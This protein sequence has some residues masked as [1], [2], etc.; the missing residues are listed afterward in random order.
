MI[1][2]K[3]KYFV[4]LS[5]ITSF[6]LIIL[7]SIVFYLSKN[8]I[9]WKS[10]AKVND[11]N[12]YSSKRIRRPSLPVPTKTPVTATPAPAVEL[13]DDTLF[14]K[15]IAVGYGNTYPDNL[16]AYCIQ[17]WKRILP[18]YDSVKW[19]FTEISERFYFCDNSDNN[20]IYSSN[21][22]QYV[23]PNAGLKKFT[24]NRRGTFRME[25][26]TGWE[27]RGGCNL[28]K[29]WLD[30]TPDPPKYGN[31]LTNWPHFLVGQIL[32][33]SYRPSQWDPGSF[34]VI[35]FN[36][37][38]YPTKYKQLTFKARVNLLDL[39]RKGDLNW[40]CPAG[41]WKP[42]SCNESVC[43]DSCDFIPNHAIFY[44]AFVFWRENRSESLPNVIYQLLPIIYSEDGKNHVLTKDS[45]VMGDQFGET[46]YFAGTG[47][48]SDPYVP[49]L[50][51]G[52]KVDIDVDIIKL[53]NKAFQ[54]ISR[55]RGYNDLN[56]K[57]Y[58]IAVFLA[59]WEIWGAYRT[60]IEVSD[61]SFK[62]SKI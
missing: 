6:L 10:K 23:S 40:N 15:G 16:D 28:C 32:S 62:G 47:N 34:G 49:S 22:I 55:F 8:S 13:L 2:K 35:P 45:F 44:F 29:K 61:I 53:T 38:I 60:D 46:V 18:E 30:V 58:Y 26:D 25:Y 37:R 14:Q 24:T 52:K 5:F 33:P 39:E 54:D 17:R 51:K 11:S 7:F 50:Q 1:R 21:L 3:N 41:D 20:P 31:P 36:E 59:G 9:L 12:D 27:W 48:G 57:D 4:I 42:N 43:N 19:M 56:I